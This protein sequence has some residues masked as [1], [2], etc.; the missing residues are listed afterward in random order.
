[1]RGTV[2]TRSFI[3][4]VAIVGIAGLSACSPRV[5]QRGAMPDVDAIA[6]IIPNKTTKEQVERSLGSPSSINMFGEETWM[7]IGETTETL[8]FLEHKVNERSVLLVR[9]NDKGVV[10]D[11]ESH[12]L[13]ESRNIVP[14]ERTTPTV[15]KSIT[16]LEQLMGN[17]NRFGKIGQEK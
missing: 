9:F 6:A 3:A 5:A 11:V 14:V 12:G 17:I 13:D 10:E 4:A 7:Y 16:V 1:M 15:G 2:I 8:A